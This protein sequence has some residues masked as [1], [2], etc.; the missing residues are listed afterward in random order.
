MLENSQILLG[1]FA[2]D[3]LLGD[4]LSRWHP[5][6]LI[7]SLVSRVELVLRR[8]IPPTRP[9]ERF[10]GLLLAAL[11][12][13]TSV[14]VTL[15]LEMLA[16]ELGECLNMPAIPILWEIIVCGFMLSTRSLVEHSTL[17][18]RVLESGDLDGARLAV[19]RIVGRDTKELDESGILRATVETVAE[20]FCDGVVAPMVFIFLAG[21]PGVVAFKV[22]STLDSMV[23]YRNELYRYFGTVGA[24]LDDILNFFP[25]RLAGFLMIL[26]SPLVG[27]SGKGAFYIFF[28]DRKNHKSPN[29]AHTEAATAGALGVRLGGGGYYG[30]KYV[31]KPYIGDEKHEITLKDIKKTNQLVVVSAL[32]LLGFICGFFQEIPA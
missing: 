3:L 14:G 27:L 12:I 18:V 24:R 2:L 16:L 23:G 21:A 20:N 22:V 25:A 10:A 9:W 28:R 19:G 7:G 5:V 6:C 13:G 15:L 8:H 29:S 32:L 17:V 1:A 31:E 4:P 26:A 30:G 11:V